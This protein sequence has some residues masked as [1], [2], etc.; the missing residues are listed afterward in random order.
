MQLALRGIAI[1]RF[2]GALTVF[3]CS[4]NVL[5]ANEAESTKP[6]QDEAAKPD[7]ELSAMLVG[8][9]GFSATNS[10][11][12]MQTSTAYRGNGS[13]EMTGKLGMTDG[14]V[15][16]SITNSGTWKITNSCLVITITN[17]AERVARTQTSSK[18]LLITTNFMTLQLQPNA[19]RNYV[20]E[21]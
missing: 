16:D 19:K 10:G 8:T 12:W 1:A 3:V 4:S 9:W 18:I 17:G 11:K 7:A 6:K 13:C 14:S 5:P 2:I 15:P 21:Q 20:R